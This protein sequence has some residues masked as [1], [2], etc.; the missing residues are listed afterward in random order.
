MCTGGFKVE[1]LL[2]LLEV[3]LQ[4]QG[5][6]RAGFVQMKRHWIFWLLIIGFLWVV[7]T[8]FT[9]MEDLAVLLSS[10]QWEWVL[11]AAF[12]Q[13]LYYLAFAG[14]YK[15]AFAT[16]EVPLRL[17]DL[18]PVTLGSRFVNVVAPS[19]GASGAA[20]FIDHAAQHGHPP[21]RSASGTILQLVADF[22]AFTVILLFG[23]VYLFLQHDLKTYEVIGALTLLLIIAGWC[24]VLALGLWRP[25]LLT[26]LLNWLQRGANWLTVHTH[27]RHFLDEDWAGRNAV[28]FTQASGAIAG[29]PTRLARTVG[30]AFLAHLLNLTSLFTLFL[31]FH[32]PIQVGALIAGYAMGILFWI[33]S[34]TPQGIGV[35]EG[36][37]TLVYTSLLVPVEAATTVS[38]AWRGLTFWLPFGLGFLFLRRSKTFHRSGG[39]AGQG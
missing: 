12:L 3:R 39:M 20:L 28:E 26:R 5:L 27:N 2:M 30:V 19:G 21:L 15:A 23:M 13:C 16:V 14:S 25:D 17:R 22:G 10:G 8:R 34:P 31:A 29:H 35:V 4:A 38:L 24:G 18:L 36:V 6:S 7:I 32:Q 1:L 33:V 37:M 9:E 11:A